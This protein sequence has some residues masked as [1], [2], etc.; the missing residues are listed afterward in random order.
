M[1]GP[2]QATFWTG[3]A[4]NCISKHNEI[5]LGHGRFLS[6]AGECN[7]GA[8]VARSVS[9]QNS[10]Y[11]SQLNVTVTPDIAGK[12]IMCLRD[13]LYNITLHLP[14]VIPTAG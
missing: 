8:I 10:L 5:S 9:V 1:G 12:T 14:T 11:T 7:K 3:T 13:N 4:F 6:A 2:G